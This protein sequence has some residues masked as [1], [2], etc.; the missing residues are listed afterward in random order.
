MANPYQSPYQGNPYNSGSGQPTN[1]N[2]YNQAN[3]NPYQNNGANNGAGGGPPNGGFGQPGNFG[4]PGGAAMQQPAGQQFGN[5]YQPQQQAPNPFASNAMGSAQPPSPAPMNFYNDGRGPIS[6]TTTTNFLPLRELS[7]YNNRWTIKARVTVKSERRKFTNAKGEGQLCSVDLVDESGG[8]TRATFFGKAVDCWYSFLEQGKVYT[9]SK[10]QVKAA[11]RKFYSK[12]EYEITF[13]ENAAIQKVDDSEGSNIPALQYDFVALN[14]LASL[15]IGAIVDVK[16]I[17]VESREPT[18][19]N[20]RTGEVKRKKSIFIVDE[21]SAKCEFTMWGEKADAQEY[22]TGF[23]IFIKNAR[24]G[25][26]GGRS[27]SSQGSSHIETAPQ[28]QR[29]FQLKTWYDNSDKSSYTALSSGGGGGSSRQT[30]EEIIEDDLTI[31]SSD[32][33]KAHWHTVCPAYVAYIVKDFAP[34]YLACPELV[35]TTDRDNKPTKRQCNKK[36]VPV[37]DTNQYS[38]GHMHEFVKPVARFIA[39]IKIQDSTDQVEA[40]M[41]DEVAEKLFQTNANEVH[42]LWVRRENDPEALKA[43]DAIFARAIFTRWSMKIKT[44]KEMYQDEQR[45]KRQIHDISPINVS[46]EAQRQFEFLEQ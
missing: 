29:A 5:A 27:L 19:V 8:E 42:E 44:V 21:S 22:S 31:F 30:L 3:F 46:E 20:L 16:G 26:F 43:L 18:N 32:A 6:R 15:D 17:V 1:G 39:R 13:D 28:D 12:G 45:I 11:N 33:Q 9:F 41:F 25:D 35:E 10:G 37:P 14:D 38:C 24:V 40:T 34:Y 36:A 4:Q 7:C 23:T 2:P